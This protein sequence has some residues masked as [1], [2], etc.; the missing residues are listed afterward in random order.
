MF[1]RSIDTVA[2]NFS[3]DNSKQENSTIQSQAVC[4]LGRPD[5]SAC[6]LAAKGPPGRVTY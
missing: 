1:C 3:M 2:S 6:G 5:L 4:K